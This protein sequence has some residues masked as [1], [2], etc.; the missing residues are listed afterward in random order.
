M[1]CFDNYFPESAAA[2]GA[3]G[4]QLILYPLYGDTLKI[5]WELK[6]RTRAIDHALYIAPCQIDK[7]FDVAYTGVVDPEGNVVEKLTEVSSYKVVEID[8]DKEVITNTMAVPGRKD[9]RKI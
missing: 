7:Y 1:I 9:R 8:L 5:D 6:L 3:K 2:L 4:A